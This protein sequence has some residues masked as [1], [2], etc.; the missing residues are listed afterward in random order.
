MPPIEGIVGGC[1]RLAEPGKSLAFAEGIETALAMWQL[2]G[3]PCWAT[4]S[5]HGMKN[6]KSIPKQITHTYWCADN[7]LSF[8]G[9]AAA[10]AAASYTKQKFNIEAEVWMPTLDE[11]DMLD[12]L[13]SK[14]H[15]E[16]LK[17][18]GR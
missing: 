6:I 17:W 1:I 15:L 9:Q 2:S 8:T 11:M 4:I 5:A 12:F 18:R 10:F 3:I 7:D 14:R 16:M 13:N